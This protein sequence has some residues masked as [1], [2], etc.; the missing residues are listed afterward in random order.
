MAQKEKKDA[1]SKSLKTTTDLSLIHIGK[2]QKAHGIK[3][4][5]FFRL[6]SGETLK[7]FPKI[8]Y[9]SN[10]KTFQKGVYRVTPASSHKF[11]SYEVLKTRSVPQG[12]LLQLKNC[13][14]RDEALKLQ[15]ASLYIDSKELK[16]QKNTHLFLSEL[17]GFKVY[18]NSHHSSQKKMV[19]LISHF[20]SHSHQDL[21]VVSKNNK[22]IEIPFVKS[23]IS[24]IDFKNKTLFLTL[25]ENFPNIL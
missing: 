8:L 10:K 5:V 3:G 14:N 22:T 17:L 23:Y 16:S 15:G 12:C 6:S 20:L 25:P 19:G 18:I 13:T 7:P 2:I 11:Q 9:I 4:E 24:D 1:I 21:I